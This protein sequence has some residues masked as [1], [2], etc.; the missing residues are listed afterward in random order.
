M[1]DPINVNLRH[2]VAP[3]RT[4]IINRRDKSQDS[5]MSLFDRY[6]QE[7]D[8]FSSKNKTP[9]LSRATKC[10]KLTLIGS[11][12]LFL[13]FACVLM[14]VGSVAYNSGVGPLTG[15][16]IPIGIIVLGVFIMFLSFLGLWGA[17]RESKNLLGCYWFWLFLL[18]LLL[19]AV[20][21]GVYSQ[22]QQAGYYIEQ[23]WL[24]T[25]PDVQQTFQNT[26]SCCGL[27]LFNDT[28]TPRSFR[29]QGYSCPTGSYTSTTS[30][31]TTFISNGQPCL[32]VMSQAFQNNFSKLGATGV[33][34]A[35]LML[36][37]LVIACVLLQSIRKRSATEEALHTGEDSSAPPAVTSEAPAV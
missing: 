26:F 30:G 18:T 36:L 9:E 16:S 7:S 37:Y 8:A 5:T 34:F 2:F 13:I 6:L 20:G 19:L 29:G 21:I 31:N 27:Y 25:T 11:N 22:K 24:T 23:G 33:S 14:G 32:P 28:Y 3:V 4:I 17:W 1:L 10:L 12:I 15:A 35:V